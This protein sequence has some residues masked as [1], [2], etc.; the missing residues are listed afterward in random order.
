MLGKFKSHDVDPKIE[1]M[2][3]SSYNLH[4]LSWLVNAK[5]A[6]LKT[7][8]LLLLLYNQE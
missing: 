7:K 8:K 6:S 3:Y 4:R 5:E 2:N 1:E